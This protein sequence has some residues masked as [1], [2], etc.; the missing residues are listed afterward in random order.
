MLYL[1]YE[2]FRISHIKLFAKNLFRGSSNNKLTMSSFNEKPCSIENDLPKIGNI[3]NKNNETLET[4]SNATYNPKRSGNKSR[5]LLSSKSPDSSQ[6][7]R[8]RSRHG[9]NKPSSLKSDFGYSKSPESSNELRFIVE[10]V[11]N[12]NG[13][14][15]L[16][17]T[18]YV[19]QNSYV[20]DYSSNGRH[21]NI[22]RAPYAPRPSA[23]STP[24]TMSPL[25]PK[26][27]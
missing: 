7:V 9:V 14:E 8:V 17:N 20:N 26:N 21:E 23:L 12:D 16:F 25:F 3:L 22:V 2:Y 11:K 1:K 10:T 24:S 6:G 27:N 15:R 18:P 13:Q 5:G 4:L 19:N